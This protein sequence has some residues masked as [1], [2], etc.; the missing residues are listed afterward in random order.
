MPDRSRARS[1]VEDPDLVRVPRLAVEQ[2]D[3]FVAFDV[4]TVVALACEVGV[5]STLD[6]GR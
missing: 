4:Q 6:R 1:H 3:E 2:V 5:G